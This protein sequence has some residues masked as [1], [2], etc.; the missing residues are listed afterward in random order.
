MLQEETKEPH[1]LSKPPTQGVPCPPPAYAWPPALPFGPRLS[2]H[3]LFT[4]EQGKNEVPPRMGAGAGKPAG[5]LDRKLSGK[6]NIWKQPS[7]LHTTEREC[8]GFQKRLGTE[9]PGFQHHSPRPL[10]RHRDS[11]KGREQ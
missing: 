3:L 1:L 2:E 10:G 9:L 4:T 7:D 5:A 8:V 6:E 11:Q